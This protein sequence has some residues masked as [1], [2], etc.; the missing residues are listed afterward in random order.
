M[1]GWSKNVFGPIMQYVAKRHLEDQISDPALRAKLQPTYPLGCKRVLISDEYYP[2]LARPNVEVVTMA[3][4]EVTS[5]AIVTEDGQE[6]RAD[7]LVFG[8]GFQS[9]DFLAPLEI[10][11]RAA[12]GSPT[13]GRTAPRPTS[14]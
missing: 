8:T 2:A 5:G 13:H 10:G 11:A 6:R 14:G 9:L 12:A 3:I 4:R 7:T 1:G